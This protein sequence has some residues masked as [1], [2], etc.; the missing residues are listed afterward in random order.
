LDELCLR[1]LVEI[2]SLKQLL[3]RGVRGKEIEG[4]EGEKRKRGLREWR[5]LRG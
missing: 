4:R 5:E 2:A 1:A 3:D